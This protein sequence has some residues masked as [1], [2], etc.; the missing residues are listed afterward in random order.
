MILLREQLALLARVVAHVH[1]RD[2]NFRD[3]R[4]DVYRPSK[5]VIFS[6]LS[7]KP[8]QLDPDLIIGI[9]KFF[10]DLE[11]ASRGLDVIS[12]ERDGPSYSCLIVLRPFVSGVQ[13]VQPI[14]TMLQHML[15]M[16]GVEEPNV[17][18]TEAVIEVEEE[19]FNRN[20]GG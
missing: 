17:G 6:N 4:T 14:L 8:G 1:M 3:F 16:P 13:E 9:S 7:G 5:P 12:A 20:P 2:Q 11:E 15:G 10:S 18:N 19:S